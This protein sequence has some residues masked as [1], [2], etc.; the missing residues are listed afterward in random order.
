MEKM[1]RNLES[2]ILEFLHCSL[3][4]GDD[5]STPDLRKELRQYSTLKFTKR[6]L[7]QLLYH[8]K[9][10]NEITNDNGTPPRWRIKAID[11][12][13]T[14]IK[15]IKIGPNDENITYVMVDCDNKPW[16]FANASKLATS[17]L[18]VIGFAGCQFNH[19]KPDGSNKYCQLIQSKTSMKDVAEIEMCALTVEICVLAE[20]KDN[21]EFILVSGDK[22][23]STLAHVLERKGAPV[24]VITTDWDDL[25]L[26]IE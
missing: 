10:A 3:K 22:S 1:S 11:T 21:L 20:D 14:K 13:Q 26:E 4:D 17:E 15:R 16:C 19:F 18:R 5:I 7:N 9:D 25:K 12:V 8:L 6:G 24:Q 23:V 2:R